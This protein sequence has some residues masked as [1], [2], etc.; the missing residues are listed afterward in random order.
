M[1]LMSQFKIILQ[2][3]S[4]RDIVERIGWFNKDIR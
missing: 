1:I 4:F 3:L 2:I